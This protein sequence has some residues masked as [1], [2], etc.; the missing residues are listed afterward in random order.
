MK[1][2]TRRILSII[3]AATL[4]ITL[5]TAIPLA[6]SAGVSVTDAEALADRINKY[7]PIDGSTRMPLLA[8]V[9]SDKKSVTVTGTV[10]GA[11]KA[12]DLITNSPVTVI[13]KANFTGEAYCCINLRGQCILDIP[14]EGSITNTKSNCIDIGGSST[15][16]LNGGALRSNGTLNA[17]NSGP[18]PTTIEINSG[19]IES[20]NTAIN[21]QKSNLYIK[22]GTI[23][24]KNGCTI[25]NHGGVTTISGGSV[26]SEGKYGA[27]MSDLEGSSLMIS[28]GT[29]QSQGELITIDATDM[30]M[31]GGSVFNEGT[32][33]AIHFSKSF[34]ITGGTVGAKTGFAIWQG[35]SDAPV[36]ISGGFLFAWGTDI[37]GDLNTNASKNYVIYNPSQV[38]T[39][40]IASPA[41]ACVWNQS[42]GLRTYMSGTS[43]DLVAGPMG[44]TAKWGKKRISFSQISSTTAAGGEYAPRFANASLATDVRPGISYK[45]GINEGFYLIS[46]ITVNDAP[47]GIGDTDPPAADLTAPTELT[48]TVS[49]S[50]VTLV[51]ND[52]SA[53]ETGFQV[54]RKEGIG[55]WTPLPD[56]PAG[57]NSYSDNNVQGSGD[58]APG[59]TY[60]YRVR[61]FRETGS[62]TVYSAY[63]NDAQCTVDTVKAPTNFT[64]TPGAS[65]ITLNWTNNATNAQHIGLSKEWA[66]GREFSSMVFDPSVSS[67]VDNAVQIGYSYTYT[68]YAFINGMEG[69]GSWLYS[70]SVKLYANLDGSMTG[71]M[72]NFNKLRTYTPGMFSD[73]DESKW[74]GFNDQKVIATAYEYGLMEGTGNGKFTPTGNMTIAQAITVAARVNRIYSTGRDDFTMGSPWYQ[75]YVDYAI[76]YNIIYASDYT[77]YNRP[78]TRAEMANIFAHALP[79]AEFPEQN[80]V[81]S[82]P[83]VS[84]SVMNYNEILILYKSGVLAGNGPT[85]T[86]N[87]TANVTRAEAAA[88]ISR[89]ILPQTRFAGK[90]FG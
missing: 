19:V 7:K 8:S 60:T 76:T 34:I 48:A 64:A 3:L 28:G 2:A 40:T 38:N 89:V 75:V 21:V 66:G 4:A 67:Y 68:L 42:K 73:V 36:I 62:S 69:A 13:W 63:S 52:N 11:N 24:T 23:S 59:K 44:A 70:E 65:S 81:N 58:V 77:D 83:D 50:N 29:V 45:N 84:L 72:S 30:L 85:G 86:Y 26:K 33:D 9:S 53:D 41:M 61:A 46:N 80:T 79:Y 56:A 27:I 87:P 12:L 49:V 5:F 16:R 43:D 88:I 22:G 15:L 20:K 39:I 54:D 74:Y 57:S 55:E 71:S 1:N 90:T 14:A 10:T 17:I 37:V 47:G 6:A 31:T 18:D 32:G 51:W 35:N 78:A 82:L 25:W